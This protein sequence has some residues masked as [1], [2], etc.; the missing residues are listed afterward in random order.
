MN[1]YQN[2]S[3]LKVRN[4]QVRTCRIILNNRPDVIILHN[5]QGTCMLIDDATLGDRN[6][7]KK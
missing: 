2:P 6:V 1:L 4:Q 3:K 5:K 7:I